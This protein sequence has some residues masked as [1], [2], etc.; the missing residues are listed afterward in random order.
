MPDFISDES[1]VVCMVLNGAI[2]PET[3]KLISEIIKLEGTKHLHLSSSGLPLDNVVSS[4]RDIVFKYQIDSTE[5][6][7]TI[8]FHIIVHHMDSDRI[9]WYDVTC[10][11]F[12]SYAKLEMSRSR[13]LL[14]FGEKSYKGWLD[15]NPAMDV[16]VD[17]P[18]AIRKLAA[19]TIQQI[20]ELRRSG[21]LYGSGT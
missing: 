4:F 6:H 8:S 5:F 18:N 20:C 2:T 15:Q 17:I 11:H 7:N 3:G 21:Q 16:S 12:D 9:N 14:P 1:Q 19:A 13:Y 10:L